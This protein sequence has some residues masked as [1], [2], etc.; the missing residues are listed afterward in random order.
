MVMLRKPRKTWTKPC[1]TTS[2]QQQISCKTTA[3]SKSGTSGPIKIL[4]TSRCAL[5]KGNVA[6]PSYKERLSSRTVC[7]AVLGSGDRV[8]QPTGNIK[9]QLTRAGGNAALSA[10]SN[11]AAF[12]A[13]RAVLLLTHFPSLN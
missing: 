2:A 5:Q 4:E 13:G 7:R 8:F 12:L 10:C 9:R 3:E 11:A 1:R 6:G